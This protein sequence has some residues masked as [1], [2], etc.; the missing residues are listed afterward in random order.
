MFSF[1]IGVASQ[2]EE[3]QSAAMLENV[4]IKLQEILQFL[5]Q[6]IGQLV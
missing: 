1:Q 2:E 4:R 3:V 5:N 6:T